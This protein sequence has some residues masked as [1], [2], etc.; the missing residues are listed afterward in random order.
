MSEVALPEELKKEMARFPGI[1]WS[2][3]AREAIEKKIDLLKRANKVFS[4]SVLTT[5]DAVE[6]GRKLSKKLGKLYEA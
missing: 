5:E 2:T 1:N 4:K 6:L 3:V